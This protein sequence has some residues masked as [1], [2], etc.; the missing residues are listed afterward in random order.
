MTANTSE[1]TIELFNKELLIFNCYQ[2]DV[3]DINFNGGKNM[4]ICFLQ[5]VFMLGK[6]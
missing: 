6:S 3:K 4:R 1:P 2:V 5:L